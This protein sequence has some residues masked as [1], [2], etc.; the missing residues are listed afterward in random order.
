MVHAVFLTVTEHGLVEIARNHGDPIAKGNRHAHEV[1]PNAKASAL[2]LRVIELDKGLGVHIEL[3]VLGDRNAKLH[4]IAEAPRG[5]IALFKSALLK[6][7][8]RVQRDTV[9]L[10]EADIQF[11]IEAMLVE[12]GR[13]N[14]ICEDVGISTPDIDLIGKAIANKASQQQLSQPVGVI[15]EALLRFAADKPVTVL[16]KINRYKLA[17]PDIEIIFSR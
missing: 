9:S 12:F 7:R 6:A 14:R 4:K 16:A 5:A 11:L 15:G 1:T 17:R 3:V 10:N 2:E 8:A 13:P